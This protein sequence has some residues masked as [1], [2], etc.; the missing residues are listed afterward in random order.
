MATFRLLITLIA[1]IVL[2]LAVAIPA[3]AV[4]A[5]HVQDASNLRKAYDFIIV[6]GGTAGLVLGDRLSEVSK[7]DILVIEYGGFINASKT[8]YFTPSYNVS[9]V[10]Q[11]RLNNRVTSLSIG[12]GVGGSSAIN[13]M[14]VMRGS[15][16][17]YDIW[18]ELGN[19]ASTWTW[20]GLLPYFKK[21]IHFVPPD[22]LM[23][24]DFNITYDIEA[25]WG[26]DRNTRL[27]TYF[28]GP[29]DARLIPGLK[30]VRDGHAGYPG[31][32]W[33]PVSNDPKTQERSYARTAHWDGLN[34]PN[35]DL[36]T[37]AKVNK[38]LFDKNNIVV[39]VQF[40]TTDNKRHTIK[41]SKEVILSA[42][43][44]HTPQILQLSGIGPSSLL[45]AA[46][47]P[48]KV[49]LPGV[50]SNFQD[51]PI[52]API[53]FNYTI[54][55]PNSSTNSSF[56][57]LIGAPV[58]LLNLATISG[59]SAAKSLSGSYSSQ[60]PASHLPPNTHPHILS[61]Y[62]AQQHLIATE[63]KNQNSLL[64]M[65]NFVIPTT[66]SVNPI[67]FH[68]LS[69]GTVLLNLSSPSSSEPIVD[70][71]ALSNP[72]DLDLLIEYTL[73][74]R[75][76]YN[77]QPFTPYQPIE[78]LP[79]ANLTSRSQ[80][81]NYIRDR[82]SP[83]GW[84]PVGTAAKMRRNLGGVVDDQLKVYGTKNLRVVDASIFPLSPGAAT[85]LTVYAVAEKAADIIKKTWE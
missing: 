12:F 34:R 80:L 71:R 66:P 45:K 7:F 22:P 21:A 82:L 17:D 15:K 74:F 38:V 26:Q 69:R 28:P 35:Y 63:L 14:A 49:D 77:S 27:Y 50:G 39:G 81:G 4:N 33:Y 37:D 23:A 32:F 30:F 9:S 78:I 55:P 11:A 40:T 56:P 2:P 52:S 18:A 62:K 67:G 25:A 5:R 54:P 41:A 36:L 13:G 84:H 43:T 72:L 70:Y 31:V 48:V 83:Q 58:A 47:I 6:G 75:R 42:G 51:H 20:D 10:P 57:G 8:K 16:R 68:I 79:G 1:I 76:F 60:Y 59:L 24:A 53:T 3:S 65:L 19:K 44:I 73:F 64:S 46:K 29:Y 85:Q 61:G